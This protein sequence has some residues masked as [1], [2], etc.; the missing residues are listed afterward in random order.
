MFD[1]RIGHVQAVKWMSDKLD[2]ATFLHVCPCEAEHHN[3]ANVWHVEVSSVASRKGPRF[4]S[5][6]TNGISTWSLHVSPCLC[7]YSSFLPQ[8]KYMQRSARGD[9][10][11]SRVYPVSHPKRDRLIVE[12]LWVHSVYKL[13]GLGISKKKQE[14]VELRD[15]RKLFVTLRV[16]ARRLQ[17]TVY[18]SSFITFHASHMFTSTSFPYTQMAALD[19]YRL[20]WVRFWVTFR[21]LLIIGCW[22]CGHSSWQYWC[23]WVSSVGVFSPLALSAPY[24]HSL[25]SLRSG[26]FEG[27]STALLLLS[28]RHFARILREG[29]CFYIF[30]LQRSVWHLGCF[31][32]HFSCLWASVRE[33]DRH[34]FTQREPKVTEMLRKN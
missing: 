17:R 28:S 29:F 18:S 21:R 10:D 31:N 3:F 27:N 11:L 25:L 32:R 6:R 15:S 2:L 8:S 30:S 20:I 9:D 24:T 1:V 14:W 13:T 7:G 19:L 16:F 26:L 34:W 33:F 22:D 5:P 4:K 12:A 23:N